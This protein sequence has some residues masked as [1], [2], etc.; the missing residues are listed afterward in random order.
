M[1]IKFWK[2]NTLVMVKYANYI[3]ALVNHYLLVA[4]ILCSIIVQ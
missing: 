4:G 1:K 3:Y 2:P